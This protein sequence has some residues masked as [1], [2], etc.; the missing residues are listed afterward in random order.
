M[1][2]LLACVRAVGSFD[3]MAARGPGWS[4]GSDQDKKL[5]F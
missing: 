1:D 2:I 4:A 3:V 5:C